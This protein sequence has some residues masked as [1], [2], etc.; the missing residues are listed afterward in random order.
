MQRDQESEQRDTQSILVDKLKF[1]QVL[2]SYPE[3]LFENFSKHVMI[4][5]ASGQSHALN[6][7]IQVRVMRRERPRQTSHPVQRVSKRQLYRGRDPS[8]GSQAVSLLLIFI[9]LVS[10]RKH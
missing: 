3:N 6:E 7:V 8:A 1:Q 10:G 9:V 4:G 2:S 5:F